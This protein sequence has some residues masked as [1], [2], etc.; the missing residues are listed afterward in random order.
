MQG[1]LVHGQQQFYAQQTKYIGVA[2]V[3][4]SETTWK[5]DLPA[6]TLAQQAKHVAL[7]ESLK[8]EKDKKLNVYINNRYAF[9]M[10]MSIGPFTKKGAS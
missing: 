3:S 5:L 6:G 10:P 2:V 4:D 1:L 9:S 8:L 7:M